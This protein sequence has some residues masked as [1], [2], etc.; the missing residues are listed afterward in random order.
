MRVLILGAGGIIGQHMNLWQPSGT[1]TVYR[2][3]FCFFTP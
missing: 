2:G 3:S 1:L